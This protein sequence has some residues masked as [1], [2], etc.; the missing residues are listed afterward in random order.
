MWTR[1]KSFAWLRYFPLSARSPAA[2]V[3]LFKDALQQALSCVSRT[4]LLASAD[5]Y[6][7][8]DPDRR[9]HTLTL[10]DVTTTLGGASR[11]ALSL[12]HHYRIA[13]LESGAVYRVTTAAYFYSLDDVAD[14]GTAVREILAYHWHPDVRLADGTQ[15]AY[16]HLH[17]NR[18]ALRLDISDGVRIAPASNLLRADLA[19]AHLPTRR[20]AL[21]DVIRLA[22]EQY[23]VEPLR[24]DWDAALRASRESFHRERTWT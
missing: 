14:P 19:A 23:G 8:F 12:D 21:E 6:R 16:P 22:I 7:D 4:I 3:N 5:G 11:L 13:R 18:G 10:A 2:A 1:R 15:I 17:I 20:S 24:G 9:P